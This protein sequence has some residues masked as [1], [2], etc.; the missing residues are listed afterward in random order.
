[1]VLIQISVSNNSKAT[2]SLSSQVEEQ[3]FSY[4]ST[5][6]KIKLN[7]SSESSILECYELRGKAL[8]GS[9]LKLQSSVKAQEMAWTIAQ[10]HIRVTFY[11][12]RIK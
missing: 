3:A 7:L 1:M 8:F 12:F 4:L 9:G 5:L 2:K 11:L 6:A 10:Q